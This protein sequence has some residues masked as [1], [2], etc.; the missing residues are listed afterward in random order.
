MSEWISVKKPPKDEH[1][2]V[3]VALN[4]QAINS[5]YPKLDTD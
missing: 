2:R 4:K 3:L 5:G 1:Q